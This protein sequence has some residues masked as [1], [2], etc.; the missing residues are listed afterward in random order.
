MRL[1]LA[2]CLTVLTQSNKVVL[3]KEEL[4]EFKKEFSQVSH[5]NFPPLPLTGFRQ[6][7]TDNSGFID[8]S[9]GA[10]KRVAFLVAVC[11]PKCQSVAL[12]LERDTERDSPLAVR[13][14]L[15]LQL[16]REPT[17]EEVCPSCISACF[18]CGCA[19]DPWSSGA[20]HGDAQFF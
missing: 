11:I 12:D 15:Q 5:R 20:G 8:I 13:V 16:N 6:V 19:A 7:D 10:K 3:T 2:Q 18:V 14:L 4:E 1:F 17:E 9:E